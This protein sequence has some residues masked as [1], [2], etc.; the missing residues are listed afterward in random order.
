M[1]ALLKVFASATL[2]GLGGCATVVKGTTQEIVVDTNPTGASCTVARGNAQIA[3]LSAT[4]GTVQVSRSKDSLTVACMKAP[5]YPTPTTQIV[6]PAFNGV[7]LG[8]VLIGGLIGVVVDASTGANH[9]YP[10]KVMIDLTGGTPGATA[11]S[12]QAPAHPP[13]TTTAPSATTMAPI[14]DETPATPAKKKKP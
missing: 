3:V 6:E 1:N 10:E 8:N 4:P 13:A 14:P 9:T 7:T 12:E 2:I 5:E 11:P